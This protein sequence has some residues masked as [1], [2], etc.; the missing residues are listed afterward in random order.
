MAR[1]RF[2]ISFLDQGNSQ[3]KAKKLIM[4][5]EKTKILQQVGKGKAVMEINEP[6]VTKGEGKRKRPRTKG[7][8]N[9][10]KEEEKHILLDEELELEDKIALEFNQDKEY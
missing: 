5:K 8:K 7:L 6:E 4:E 2:I 1:A 9:D 10:L 3:L